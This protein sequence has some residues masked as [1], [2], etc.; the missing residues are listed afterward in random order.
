MKNECERLNEYKRILEELYGIP[1]KSNLEDIEQDIIHADVYDITSSDNI[2]KGVALSKVGHK[3]AILPSKK[4]EAKRCLKQAICILKKEERDDRSNKILEDTYINLI[5]LCI[6][7]NQFDE[8]SENL[9]KYYEMMEQ[10]EN[11]NKDGTVKFQ[12]QMLRKQLN[13]FLLEV[14]LLYRSGEKENALEVYKGILDMC[15]IKLS[16]DEYKLSLQMGCI[17]NG[18]Y[19]KSKHTFCEIRPIKGEEWAR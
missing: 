12:K 9:E 3:L 16:E 7:E 14:K 4:Q 19:I 10:L 17:E 6:E 11:E 13:G 2:T 8:A 5:N 15:G 1:P 18:S